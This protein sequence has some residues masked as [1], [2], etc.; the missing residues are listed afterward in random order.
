MNDAQLI[1][2]LGGVTAVARL[3]GIAPSS[4]SGWKAIPL[5]RKIRLA[6]IAEDLGLTTRKELF[7]DNYQD[8]WIE[9]RPQTTKSKN[10]GSLTA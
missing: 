7:P 5:D 10:L 2:K 3:L 1:D 9:L 8:I 6:V 4:V